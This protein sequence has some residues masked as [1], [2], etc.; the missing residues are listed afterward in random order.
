MTWASDVD[1]DC[2]C[3]DVAKRGDAREIFGLF[4]DGSTNSG[5]KEEVGLID[6]AVASANAFTGGWAVSK[7]KSDAWLNLDGG[8]LKP[9]EAGPLRIDGFASSELLDTWLTPAC[10]KVS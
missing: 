7:T 1:G 3:V 8:S 9:P 5:C 2:A 10:A 4:C 6:T